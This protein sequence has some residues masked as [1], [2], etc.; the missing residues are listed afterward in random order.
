MILVLSVLVFS[1]KQKG[2]PTQFP[3]EA[4]NATF[5]SLNGEEVI[6]DTI[7]EKHQ[8]KTI[9]IDIWATWCGDCLKTLPQLQKVQAEHRE[10]V[11]VFL[12]ADRSLEPAG[13]PGDP[14]RP[15]RLRREHQRAA[16]VQDRP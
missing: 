4:L 1:C 14:G 6:F 15:G 9:I 16:D 5:I 7:I 2:E 10:V 12:S 11:F 13:Q 8:G 3:Q